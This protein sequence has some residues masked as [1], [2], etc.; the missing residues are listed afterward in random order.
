MEGSMYAC[1]ASE[2]IKLIIY[3]GRRLALLQVAGNLGLPI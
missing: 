3:P 1:T 2:R